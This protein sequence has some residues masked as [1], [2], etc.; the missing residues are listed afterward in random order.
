MM[1]EVT[2]GDEDRGNNVVAKHL[3]VILATL[4]DVEDDNL[5]QPKSPLR[6]NISLHQSV[7]FSVWPVGPHF[8]QI[9]VIRRL[10]VDI[11]YKITGISMSKR[12]GSPR[13]QTHHAHGPKHAVINKQPG[14]FCKPNLVLLLGHAL[15]SGN[16]INEELRMSDDEDFMQES[17]EEQ[18][19][20]VTSAL[21]YSS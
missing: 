9:E 5:L 21:K 12:T 16:I 1:V 4:L 14:L 19:G 7:H 17:D 10:A 15:H 18:Y 8:T 11:L 13:R 20:R 3:P 6:Q 2:G